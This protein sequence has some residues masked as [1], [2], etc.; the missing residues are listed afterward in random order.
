MFR[1]AT[2]WAISDPI[3]YIYIFATYL[4]PNSMFVPMVSPIHTMKI[5]GERRVS[6][7]IGT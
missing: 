7:N 1:E 3:N 5:L 2:L 4:P 6:S